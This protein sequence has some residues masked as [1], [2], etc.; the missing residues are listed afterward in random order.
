[1][2]ISSTDKL[3]GIS[4]LKVRAVIRLAMQE[5]LYGSTKEAIVKTVAKTI[6]A[7]FSDGK[8]LFNSLLQDDYLSI[9]KTKLEGAEC[10]VSETEKGRHL[11]VTRANPP[12][13][14][15]KA[16]SLLKELLQ[17]VKEVNDTEHY[18]Y[19]IASVKI[20]GSYLTDKDIL[21]D[22]DVAIELERKAE[23][24]AYIEWCHKRTEIAF[25]NGRQFGNYI[26]QLDWARREVLMHLS[27]HKKGLSIHIDGEDEIVQRVEGKVV[28]QHN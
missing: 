26:E 13:K 24:E 28:Y 3:Y 27:T 9:G 4:I 18:V 20:F 12:I 22:L 19:R 15:A 14:R 25:S 10:T 11:G 8:K 2:R 7:S 5:R 16:D 17:R 23:G 21:G 1:M 6:D